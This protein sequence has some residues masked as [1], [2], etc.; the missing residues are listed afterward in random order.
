MPFSEYC[1][2]GTTGAAHVA[3]ASRIDDRCGVHRR[4]LLRGQ[5]HA[6]GESQS[7]WKTPETPSDDGRPNLA[8]FFIEL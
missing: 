5:E 4:V 6:Q 1:G 7:H 8:G 2:G 3:D